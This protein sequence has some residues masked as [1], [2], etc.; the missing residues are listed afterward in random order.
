VSEACLCGHRKLAQR[1]LDDLAD[2]VRK[3]RTHDS[4]TESPF[5]GQ[6]IALS[7]HA[8]PRSDP[9]RYLDWPRRFF[10]QPVFSSVTT[11]WWD[12]RR[13]VSFSALYV[14]DG[15][16]SPYISARR[17]TAGC[18]STKRTGTTNNSRAGRASLRVPSWDQPG[19]G[20]R[21]SFQY[22][23]SGAFWTFC[24][25]SRRF[26]AV[27]TMSGRFRSCAAKSVSPTTTSPVG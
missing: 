21:F 10:L 9:L 8:R 22:P 23:L 13:S 24:S 5:L 7:P 26:N 15:R 20:Y 2:Q 17:S 1:I 25:P 18:K 4:A 11:C 16:E 3:Q 6:N 14:G 19:G 12:W 27:P